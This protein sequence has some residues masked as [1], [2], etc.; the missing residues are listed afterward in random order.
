MNSVL[1]VVSAADHWTL[2]DGTLHPTG[3]W[4]EELAE[5][6]RQFADAGWQ[7][8]I[9]TPGGVAPTIDAG[10]LSPQ[11]AGGVDRAAEI[12]DYLGS[13]GSEL[14][15]PRSISD[16]VVTDYDVVFYP[17]GHGPMEDLAVDAVS[18]RILTEALDSGRILGVLCHAPAALLAARRDDG[19]WPFTGYRMTGF[20]DEE[21]TLGGLAPKAP[22]LVQS[23]LVELGA[24]FVAGAPWGEHMEIDRNLYTGQNPASSAALATAIIKAVA[25]QA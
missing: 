7:I 5:P 17:G 14:D 3:Y 25:A 8:T 23:R 2:N 15:E 22:W 6:H 21:E 1:F 12:V 13:I 16:V 11:A 4:A 20:T 18:G 19:T 24:D 10:S 9:A